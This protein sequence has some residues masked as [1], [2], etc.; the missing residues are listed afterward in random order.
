MPTPYFCKNNRNRVQSISTQGNVSPQDS[1]CPPR[2][3]AGCFN[4]HHRRQKAGGCL[5]GRA[6]AESAGV[7]SA[8]VGL[9]VLLYGSLFVR[10]STPVLATTPSLS[11]GRAAAD[12]CCWMPPQSPSFRADLLLPSEPSGCIAITCLFVSHLPSPPRTGSPM[13]AGTKCVSTDTV[14]LPQLCDCYLNLFLSYSNLTP[15]WAN[16][17]ILR[18]A[19]H[20]IFLGSPVKWAYSYPL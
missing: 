6:W 9:A 1:W 11:P 16:C 7:G 8:G 13:K 4:Q 2:A 14:N 19:N 17:M 18:Q 20:T 10:L 15:P 5:T 3:T 12:P